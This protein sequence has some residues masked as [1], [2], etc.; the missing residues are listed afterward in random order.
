MW[1]KFSVP[2]SIPCRECFQGGTSNPSPLG[3]SCLILVGIRQ[4]CS[5]GAKRTDRFQTSG[6]GIPERDPS[7]RAGS[8]G[9][10]KGRG[11]EGGHQL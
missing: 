3:L 8:Q 4:H 2:W 10:G 11:W 5:S 7:E 6:Q 1:C 9:P